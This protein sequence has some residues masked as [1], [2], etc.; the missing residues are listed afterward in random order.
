MRTLALP[1]SE[2][3]SEQEGIGTEADV[4][5][6]SLAACREQTEGGG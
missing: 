3:D 5:S 2:E 4:H 6:L 1:L